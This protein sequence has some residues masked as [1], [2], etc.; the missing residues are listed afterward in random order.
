MRYYKNSFSEY[1][2][3]ETENY[4]NL[5]DN[6]RKNEK[7]Q[8]FYPYSKKNNTNNLQKNNF[9]Y[10]KKDSSYKKNINFRKNSHFSNP[11]S[12]LEILESQCENIIE[13]DRKMTQETNRNFSSNLI[14]IKYKIFKP[15]KILL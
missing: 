14:F 11:A 1:S 9:Y 15:L 7:N 4:N 12:N 3:E 13:Q 2:N 6:E 5:K 10:N 8:D